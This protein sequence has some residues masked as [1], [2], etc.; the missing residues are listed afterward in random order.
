M[1]AH[2]YF[3]YAAVCAAP[4]IKS[5]FS[6]RIA[7]AS[8]DRVCRS[9]V[10]AGSGVALFALPLVVIG[11]LLVSGRFVGEER[12]LALARALDVARSP[13]AQAS[14]ADRAPRCRALAVRSC[15]AD[16]ARPARRRRVA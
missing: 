10:G 7:F 2:Q 12:I 9:G 14:L 5:S 11:A 4:A 8:V 1:R 15:A 6:R 3:R 13:C 16:V